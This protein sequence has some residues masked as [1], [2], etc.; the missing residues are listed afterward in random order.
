MRAIDSIYLDHNASTPLKPE[1]LEAMLRVLTMPGNASSIH[2][3][4]RT[5]R[6]HIEAA[7][8]QV[9]HLTQ[10]RSRAVI[11]FTSG[12]TEANNLI[13]K[14]AGCRRILVSAIEHLSVLHAVESKEI[15][16]VLKEGIVDLAALDAMLQGNDGDVLISVMAVNNETGVIQPIEEVMALAL[17]HGA[18]LHVD[19]VQAAGKIPI[20][21]QK[22]GVDFM[23]LSSHKIGGPQGVGCLIINNCA[24]VRPLISGGGQEKYLRAGTENL[25]GIVGFGVACALAERDMQQFQS[26][27]KWRD[28]IETR[29][30]DADDTLKIFGKNSPRVA[31]T[32]MFALPFA[33]AET[34]LIALDLAGVSVSNGSACSSG[35]VKESHVLK[36]MGAAANEISSA[37]RVSLGWNTTEKD[38]ETFIA[39]WLNMRDRIKT[40]LGTV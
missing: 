10:A 32:S 21:L 2:K 19:A 12:A 33:S 36:A 31:N 38:V 16:P 40:R 20:N 23:T 37:L 8:E 39:Q 22:T 25:A 28:Q 34:Q 26:L 1:V 17:K 3:V 24:P 5:A 4:G 30:S 18:L 13:L 15:I 14:G 35:T 9:A 27:E 6:R 7:R 11:V 29:L